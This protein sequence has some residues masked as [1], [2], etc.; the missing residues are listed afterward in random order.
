MRP[1]G[2]ACFVSGRGLRPEGALGF[3]PEELLVDPSS[4]RPLPVPLPVRGDPNAPRGVALHGEHD[5]A[6]REI[7]G[8]PRRLAEVEGLLGRR[9]PQ[10]EFGSLPSHNERLVALV[11][12]PVETDEVGSDLGVA[13]LGGVILPCED[14]LVPLAVVDDL[15]GLEAD[16]LPL[17]L[18]EVA[19]AVGVVRVSDG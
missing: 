17:L 7:V 13:A 18:G 8:L 5:E 15:E 6:H 16:V 4:L 9:V 10:R 19:L 1:Y 3:Y 2:C 14:D 11:L 12:P